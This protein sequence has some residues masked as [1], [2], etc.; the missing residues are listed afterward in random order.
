MLTVVSLFLTFSHIMSVCIVHTSLSIYIITF[1]ES[2]IQVRGLASYKVRINSPV[3]TLEIKNITVVTHLFDVFELLI[4]P[5]NW[6]P[7]WIFHR[8]QYFSD[9]N[10]FCHEH[11]QS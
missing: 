6:D 10:L 9:F 1:N 7:V 5:F 2:V 3:S 8:V 11:S 4:L